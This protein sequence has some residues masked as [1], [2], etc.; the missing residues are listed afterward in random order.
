MIF[1]C[2]NCGGNTVYSPEQHRMYCP[3]CQSFD[4]EEKITGQPPT[5][6]SCPNCG[7]ELQI[8]DYLS[9]SR[10]PYC[11]DYIIFDER[12]SGEYEPR[13]IIP[14][15]IGKNRVKELMRT[16]FKSCIFAPDDFCSDARLDSM[17]GMYVPYWIFDFHA[18]GRFE[19]T[20]KK[21]RTWVSEEREFT[22]TQIYHIV[23]D[24]EVTFDKVPV[25]ASYLMPDQTMD[26]L[27]PYRYN[28]MEDFKEAY[29]SGFSAEYYNMD[30]SEAEPR[31]EKKTR[32]DTEDI[33]QQSL[34]GY[35]GLEKGPGS[36]VT[37]SQTDNQYAL[38][39]VWIYNY[40]YKNESYLFYVNGQT[41]K[42]V[43]KVPVS[44]GKVWGYGATVFACLS[45]ILILINGIL[46]ML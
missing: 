45:I 11:E 42:I 3:F 20:G 35:V 12:V 32:D 4:S 5:T 25:D 39:P 24:M 31:A 43:G 33:L 41:G 30:A 15:M 7:G 28:Q 10:C 16:K 17:T 8:R 26:L 1:K 40:I 6:I 36:A 19:G 27:E 2:R 14:F 23:R 38:M 44:K 22:E 21:V 9:A 18:A 29:L 46:T 13:L 34:T 37:I